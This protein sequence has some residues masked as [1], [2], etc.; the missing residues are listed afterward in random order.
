[1]EWFVFSPL[2]SKVSIPV[3][4]SAAAI[5][6]IAGMRWC[7]SNS[8]ILRVLLDKKY[9]LPYVITNYCFSILLFPVP[10]ADLLL[11]SSSSVSWLM[12]Y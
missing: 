9:S 6:K 2:K 12:V 4:H 7:P 11:P 8:M 5:Q 10:L 3:V 1:M